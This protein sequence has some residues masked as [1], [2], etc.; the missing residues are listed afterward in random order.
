[1]DIDALDRLML[2]G[3]SISGAWLK[4]DREYKGAFYEAVK[5]TPAIIGLSI[6]DAAIQGFNETV[7]QNLIQMTLTNIAFAAI[8]AFG[9]VY[10]SARISV[11]E[12]GRELAS[13][14]VLGFTR[15]E[16]SAILLGELAILVLLALPLGMVT[17]YVIAAG[18]VRS[19][20][21][22][23][24]KLPLVIDAST[25]AWTALVVLGA[26]TISALVVRRRLDRLD[27]VAVL[28]T[29]E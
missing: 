12:R 23:L 6:R 1:M 15:A 24:F 17:G 27:L 26:A 28:K 21:T 20:Q 18:V 22:E 13:M 29:R 8:I 19:L 2:E 4:L 5:G 16:I 3:S 10:N 25:Y 11:S 9:V 14:R 7:G